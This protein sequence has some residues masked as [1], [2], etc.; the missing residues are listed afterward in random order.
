M[1]LQRSGFLREP[2]ITKNLWPTSLNTFEL[3][4]LGE[5]SFRAFENAL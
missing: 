2:S 4:E 5:L 1:Q 3:G